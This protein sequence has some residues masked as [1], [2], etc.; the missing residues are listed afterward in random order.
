MF[1]SCLLASSCSCIGWHQEIGFEV[2]TVL[3][4]KR[5]ISW[6]VTPCSP[7]EVLWRFEGT[8]SVFRVIDVLSKQ[9]TRSNKLSVLFATGHNG[10]YSDHCGLMA[11]CFDIWDWISDKNANILLPK[12]DLAVSHTG[13]ARELELWWDCGIY[14]RQYLGSWG[15]RSQQQGGV[16]TVWPSLSAYIACQ[17]IRGSRSHHM[18][19][20]IRQVMSLVI[21]L[22]SSKML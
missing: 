21:H 16:C 17:Q 9:W 14:F 19:L 7:V 18:H 13:G 2:L 12:L 15:V 6:D 22:H 3:I 5:T 4:M 8:A 1:I 10:I 20:F 11:L